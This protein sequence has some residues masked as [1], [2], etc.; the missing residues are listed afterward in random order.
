M[1]ILAAFALI[2]AGCGNDTNLQSEN[3]KL[4]QELQA[5]DQYVEEMTSSINDIHSQLENAWSMEKNV[6][7][8]T[9]N[10]EGG[11]KLTPAEVKMRIFDRISS[12]DSVLASNK[13]KVASLLYRLK[14]A[15]T[16]YAGL[17][18]MVDDLKANLDE[19]E[20]SIADLQDRVQ[21]LEGEVGNKDRVIAVQ[22]TTIR[23][24]NRQ[25]F[26]R[27]RQLNTVYYTI[28]DRSTLRDEGLIEDRGGVL[29]GLLGTTTVLSSAYD[30]G[31]FHPL[32]KTVDST[33]DVSGRIDELVPKRD[34]NSYAEVGAGDGHTI[35]R[36][37]DPQN[38]WRDT[39]LVVI[40]KK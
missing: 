11:H 25:L 18:K 12:I 24:Q 37:T 9:T 3:D 32:D 1:K 27:T 17:K 26:N 14:T 39:R 2:V 31:F 8:Q 40:S 15:A 34:K 30:N 16:Q 23:T 19:R 28:G 22:D 20:K 7:R 5:K 21:R 29:W 10:V 36:I 33:I 38:F 6:V 13:K 4:K 35:L